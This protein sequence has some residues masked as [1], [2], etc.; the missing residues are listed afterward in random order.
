MTDATADSIAAIS[1]FFLGSNT[2]IADREF[3][4][5]GIHH[6][7]VSAAP[8]VAGASCPS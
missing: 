4:A 5:P 3:P 8:G 2:L 7:E 6:V 1:N